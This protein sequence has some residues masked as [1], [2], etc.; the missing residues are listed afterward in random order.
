MKLLSFALFCIALFVSSA[1]NA[2][3]FYCSDSTFIA[4]ST[5]LD[6]YKIT[7]ASST[8]AIYFIDNDNDGFIEVTNGL[9]LLAGASVSMKRP[10][11]EEEKAMGVDCDD[12][13]KTTTYCKNVLVRY[14]IKD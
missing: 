14:E 5:Q 11:I 2:S 4:D 13:D 1:V 3:S 8:P 6:S 12:E 10:F 7:N 9:I